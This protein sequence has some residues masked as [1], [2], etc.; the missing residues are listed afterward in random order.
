MSISL[1]PTRVEWRDPSGALVWTD[2]DGTHL[3][4]AGPYSF[5]MPEVERLFSLWQHARDVAASGRIP[6]P[7]IPDLPF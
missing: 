5:E 3:R 2:E 7:A 1:T 4:V 6:S